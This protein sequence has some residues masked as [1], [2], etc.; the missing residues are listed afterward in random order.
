M[1]EMIKEERTVEDK[2]PIT[3]PQRVDKAFLKDKKGR[4]EEEL[5][6]FVL[7]LMKNNGHTDLIQGVKAGEF[8]IK[9]ADGKQEKSIMLTPNKLTTINYNKQ[10]FKGWIAHED[11]M[12]PYPQDP[13][14]NAEMFRKATQK[15]AMN[16]RDANDV[17]YL[18]AKRKMWMYIIGGILLGIY[19]LY[20]VG[21]NAGWFAGGDD[22]AVTQAVVNTT[23]AVIK[24]TTGVIAG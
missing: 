6:E 8:F 1:T 22:V 2:K 7:L 10:Y 23:K 21:K 18:D 9:S 14:H 11:N 15:L 19:V 12:S 16:Y 13:L 3:R 4:P 17:A 5:Q 20:I 24:N